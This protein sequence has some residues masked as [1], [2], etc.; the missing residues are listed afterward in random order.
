MLFGGIL[1]AQ[2][3]TRLSEGLSAVHSARTAMNLDAIESAIQKY[4]VK[5]RT[6]NLDDFHQF[7]YEVCSALS[8][9]HYGNRG[10]QSR[11]L[12]Q[13]VL[14]VLDGRDQL[15]I[16]E[17]EQ[18]TELLLLDPWGITDPDWSALRRKKA[19]LWLEA[20]RR[21]DSSIDPKFDFS[22]LPLVNVPPPPGVPFGA[23]G[24]LEAIKDP[25]LR[26]DYEA[27][28][29]RNN[30]KASRHME[31][32]WLK[33]TIP[34]FHR[35]AELYIGEAYSKPPSAISELEKLLQ[36]Y[37]SDSSARS[38]VLAAVKKNDKGAGR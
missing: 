38:R 25:R 7:M 1:L 6:E 4:S 21:L 17:Q 9:H 27:A 26:A 24:V 33:Q 5:L 15:S 11:L 20:W 28:V 32:G 2:P 16:R 31:Q 12:N 13:Y 36:E 14:A 18:F 19:G 37:V 8:S 23:G 10:R 30:A 22:D 34:Q 35:L 3:A 29:A